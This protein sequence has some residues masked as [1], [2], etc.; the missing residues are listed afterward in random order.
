MTLFNLNFNLTSRVQNKICI[1]KSPIKSLYTVPKRFMLSEA[2]SVI[3]PKSPPL[4][5]SQT[6]IPVENILSENKDEEYDYV[7]ML[8]YR[9]EVPSPYSSVPQSSPLPTENPINPP[10]ESSNSSNQTISTTTTQIETIVRIVSNSLLKAK[11]VN[12]N[13]SKRGKKPLNLKNLISMQ[14]IWLQVLF[15]V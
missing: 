3:T 2:C 9:Q 14:K 6:T 1:L 10:S 13:V 5:C 4:P 15:Q 8:G 12:K 11:N 7:S